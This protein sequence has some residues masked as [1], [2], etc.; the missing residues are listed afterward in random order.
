MALLI[1]SASCLILIFLYD[2]IEFFTLMFLNSGSDFVKTFSVLFGY[3]TAK[4]EVVPTSD[5]LRHCATF[6]L[7]TKLKVHKTGFQSF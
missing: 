2:S 4:S 1:M 7:P 6:L 5:L 3:I